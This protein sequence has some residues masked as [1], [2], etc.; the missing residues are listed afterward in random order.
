MNDRTHP[1]ARL[2]ACYARHTGRTV[3]TISLYATGS[4]ATYARLAA[5]RDITTRRAARV[6]QW[7]S[8]HWPAGAEWPSDI[9]RPTPSPDGDPEPPAGGRPS[10]SAVSRAPALPGAGAS[11]RGGP[12]P[13][14]TGP[15]GGGEPSSERPAA[16][17]Q[18]LI[19]PPPTGT[20]TA[21]SAGLAALAATVRGWPL[22]D[23]GRIRDAG[24]LAG[25]IGVRRETIYAVAAYAD[26]R[27]RAR[28]YPRG[29]DSDT[30]RTLL[31]LL[32]TGDRRFA[33]RRRA[34]GPHLGL[35]EAA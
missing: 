34:V 6:V 7:L 18:Q 28:R 30:Y 35:R 33:G 26:D 24:T 32:A 5:G 14:S 3:G 23:Q 10:S 25:L 31:A 15:T 29:R 19:Q 12:P 2:I 1:V 9:P 21:P 17:F 11:A 16:S 8:D 13:A 4:G 27:P 22:D 20:V